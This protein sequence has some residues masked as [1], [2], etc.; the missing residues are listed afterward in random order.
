MNQN[1]FFICTYTARCKDYCDEKVFSQIYR[2]SNGSPVH[3]VDNSEGNDYT[4][5]LAAMFEHYDN[6]HL[7]YLEVDELPKETRFHRSVAESVSFLRERFLKTDLP[8]F[9]IIESD[10]LPPLDL[11][12][13]L[14]K[15]I[16]RVEQTDPDWGAIGALYYNGFHDFSK[17]SGLYKTHHTLSGCTVYNRKAIEKIPFRWS[18]DNLVPFPDAWWSYDA[19]QD[20]GLYN[21]HSIICRHLTNPE[22]GTRYSR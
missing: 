19:G 13:R 22:T 17:K 14:E 2:L 12:T 10:V 18:P 8:Y 6:F 5:E 9:L 16:E 4:E 20:F 3:V 15:S 7:Y 1:R 21:D 11:L